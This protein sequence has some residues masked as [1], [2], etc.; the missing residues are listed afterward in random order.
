MQQHNPTQ[1]GQTLST[2]E[3]AAIFKVR[4]QSIRA[5]LCRNGHYLGMRPAKPAN[6]R[7]LWSAAE[8]ASVL[9]GGAA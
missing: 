9:N 3:L 8:A 4:P 5:S 6:R 1:V 2:E 7:L